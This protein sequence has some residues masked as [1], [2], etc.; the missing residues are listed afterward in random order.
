MQITA[1]LLN[2]GMHVFACMATNNK[3]Q[4]I[5][6]AIKS[7][8]FHTNTMGVEIWSVDIVKASTETGNHK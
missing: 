6:H 1:R 4:S 7:F 3:F 5:C 8:H 2:S